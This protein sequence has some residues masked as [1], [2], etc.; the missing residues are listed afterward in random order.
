MIKIY[1]MNNSTL[2]SLGLIL[3]WAFVVVLWM[4]PQITKFTNIQSEKESLISKEKSLEEEYNKLKKIDE[5]LKND[6]SE[7]EKYTKW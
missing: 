5:E 7:F 1:K 6:S 3:I 2:K 4:M